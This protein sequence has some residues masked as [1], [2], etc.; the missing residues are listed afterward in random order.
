[1]HHRFRTAALAGLLTLLGMPAA[2]AIQPVAEG[3]LRQDAQQPAR[4]FS[5]PALDA[6]PSLRLDAQREVSLDARIA[7]F[8]QRYGGQW[9]VRWD[10][11]GDRPNV[12]Q[13]SGIALIPGRGNAL[14]PQEFGLA[15]ESDMN[16]GI[17]AAKARAFIASVPELLA[18]ENLELKLD[19]ERS[20]LAGGERPVWF[21][22]FG[23]H[24]DGVRVDGAYVYVRVAQGNIVQFGA[25]RIADVQI[26]TQPAATREDAFAQAWTQFGFRPGAA[27]EA[28]LQPGE[29]RILPALPVGE[30]AGERFSGLRG[31]GYRHVL[32]WRYQFRLAGDSATWQAL[33]DAQ[34]HRV[35]ELRDLTV[36][37][38]ATVTGGVYPTTNSDTEIIVPLPFVA[39]S[40]GSAKVT[41]TLGIYDYSGGTATASLDGK[42]FRMTDT[43]GSISMAHSGDGNIAF[44]SSGGT[45]CIT[46]GS[47]GAGNTHASRSG[48]YHL[49]RINEKARTF[50]PA[51]TWLQGKVTANMNIVNTC[52]AFWNGSTL[53]FYKS[54]P[55]A[56]NPNILCSNTGEIAAVFL[57]EWGHGMDTNTGGAA[58][59]AGSGEAVGDTFAF[60]ETRD[61]CIG[62]NFR[63][64]LDCP[65]CV[66]CTGVRDVGD[67]GLSAPAAKLASPANLGNDAGINCDRYACPYTTPDGQAYRGPM[68]YEGHCESVIASGANWDL[69]QALIEHHGASGWG[70]MDR[71]WYASLTPSKS[72]Y[73]VS[74]GG[75]CN[76]AASVDGCGANNWYTVFLTADDDDGNL[77]NGTP[78][79]CRI[80]DAMSAHGIG[81]GTRPACSGDTADFRLRVNSAPQDVCAPATATFA[82][83]VIGDLGFSGAVTLA[84]SGPA[85]AS[86]SF[87]PNP[88]LPGTTSTATVN[89]SAMAASSNGTLTISGTA[90]GSP[91]HASLPPAFLA[92]SVGAPAAPTATAPANG[93]TAVNAGAAINLSWAA[94]PN[95]SSY[96][97]EIATDVAF[98]NIV[99]SRTVNTTSWGVLG[100]GS[101]QTYY[102]R[103]RAANTC[104]GGSNSAVSSF[105]TAALA[106]SCSAGQVTQTLFASDVE[107]D[108][109]AWSTAG[110]TGSATWAVSTARPASPTRSWLAT[111]LTATSDQRLVTP[112]ITLPADLSPLTL[113][114]FN[115]VNLEESSA[116]VCYDGGFVEISTNNGT[117]WTQV[118]AAQLLGTPYTGNIDGGSIQA[119]CGTLPYRRTAVNL[120]SLAGQTVRLRFR[121]TTDSSAG[122]APHGWYVDDIRVEGCGSANTDAIFAD[123]FDTP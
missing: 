2:Q 26:A 22:E 121:V 94:V 6:Q 74:A 113:S 16:L 59:E 93:A 4:Q 82:V 86:V 103:V 28:F 37:V 75:Q 111:D 76:L 47:G 95:V 61:S 51:N 117:S 89:T 92:V 24:R 49:T 108:M 79:A 15:Q 12:V 71:I 112:A 44:G 96:T 90:A 19:S 120:T 38:N 88:A 102:W 62:Q 33:V 91:G 45:D 104:G 34:N 78:N 43:C 99:A 18:A 40:N 48:F 66:A 7:P 25:E 67:F 35:L 29:L 13:G 100:L 1:M 115:D 69:T 57:H 11:R 87:S 106:G 97:V 17:V 31:S 39:V 60:L 70:K 98:A 50:F 110:S 27:V 30:A 65:N 123:G 55:S 64:G 32:A 73:R 42:Y 116:T 36:N 80:W 68:G 10:E 23:Q 8:Q 77:A 85:G 109:S 3:G 9:D 114:F 54:G 122:D 105:T 41:D 83:D 118:S 52:N 14:K 21:L 107:G 58:S 84:G 46:P 119:W 72:A 53:N 5:D 56:S 101:L 81:C 20:V 63:P